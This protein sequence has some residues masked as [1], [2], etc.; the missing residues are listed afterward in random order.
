MCALTVRC[1]HMGGI[2]ACVCVWTVRCGHMLQ[3]RVFTM[4]ECFAKLEL[5]LTAR[6]HRLVRLEF[7]LTLTAR[8]HRLLRLELELRLTAR[9]DRL[10]RLAFKNA[11]QRL[12]FAG[13]SS[14]ISEKNG[15]Q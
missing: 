15:C 10:V 8:G 9:G 1:G 13:F 3:F 5:R 2:S 4:T 14:V 6:G 12:R 7:E 11:N